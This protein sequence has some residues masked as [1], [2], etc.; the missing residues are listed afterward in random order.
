MK[1]FFAGA[2]G[3]I[4]RR[5]TPLLVAV[6]HSVIGTTRSADKAEAIVKLGAQPVT[7]D[8]F[9]AAAVENAV[10]AAKPD[11]IIHQLTDLAF[12]PGTPQYEAGLK[13]NARIRVEGTANLVAAAKAAGVKRMI[14]QSVAWLY[15]PGPRARTESDALATPEGAAATTIDGVNALES[16]VLALPE[17]VVLRY[18][19]FYGPGTW[20]PGGPSRPPAVHIDAAA[21]ASALALTKARPGIYNVADDDPMLSSDKA[22]RELGFKPDFRVKP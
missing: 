14:A 19:F 1:V 6:G 3:A 18:G 22:K 2:G 7:V 5:L 12:A 17:G 20:S 13:R 10:A 16:A 8:V 9:D 4:G 11:A 15:K 21:Q